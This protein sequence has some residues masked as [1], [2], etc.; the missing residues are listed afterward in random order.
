MARPLAK[1]TG[2]YRMRL[3]PPT[4]LTFLISILLAILAIVGQ[5]VQGVSIYIP[6][7]TFWVAIAAYVVLM[8]GNLVRGF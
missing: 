4:N 8:L 6:V 3:T 7:S 2:D 5:F 1:H